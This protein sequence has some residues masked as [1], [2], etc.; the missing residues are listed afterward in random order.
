MHGVPGQKL[1]QVF[2]GFF[3]PIRWDN[4]VGGGWSQEN[5]LPSGEIRPW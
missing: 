2:L 3:P 4:K 5:A 1:S